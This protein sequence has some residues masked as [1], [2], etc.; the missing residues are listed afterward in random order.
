MLIDGGDEFL[1]S[2]DLEILLVGPIC[3]GGAI[4]RLAP[5]FDIR[6]FWCRP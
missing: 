4:E 6:G 2:E 1:G 3:R 5:V